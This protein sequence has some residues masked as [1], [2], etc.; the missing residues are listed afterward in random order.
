MPVLSAGCLA[1]GHQG[2]AGRDNQVNLIGQS[3]Y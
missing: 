3:P 1:G 2:D